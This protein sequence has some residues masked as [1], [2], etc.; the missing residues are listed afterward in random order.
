MNI[1]YISKVYLN[2]DRYICRE[3]DMERDFYLKREN[4]QSRANILNDQVRKEFEARF[5]GRLR[6][7]I[8]TATREQKE[9]DALNAAGLARGKRPVIPDSAI[10]K[11]DQSAAFSIDHYWYEVEGHFVGDAPAETDEGA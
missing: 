11:F 9:L 5:L 4:A 1:F 6:E 7:K 3:I 8:S 10:P 2:D